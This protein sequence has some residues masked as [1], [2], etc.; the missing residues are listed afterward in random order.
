MSGIIEAT[1][2]DTLKVNIAGTDYEVIVTNPLPSLSLSELEKALETNRGHIDQAFKEI[3][4]TY[5]Q[6]LIERL[7][8]KQ[9]NYFSPTQLAV[10]AQFNIRTLI[11]MINLRGGHATFAK[12]ETFPPEKRVN[13]MHAL[14]K[15]QVLM[16]NVVGIP[17][18]P[19]LFTGI[20]IISILIIF[21][22]L[23]L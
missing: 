6:D 8:P 16:E 11:P 10:M 7:M 14:A 5:K 20:I 19:E 22:F 1:A 4:I 15:K 13:A 3:K 2:T 9:L 18:P 23:I 21:M 17:L 12:P